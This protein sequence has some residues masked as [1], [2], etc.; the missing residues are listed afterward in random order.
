MHSHGK[1]GPHPMHQYTPVPHL[2]PRQQYSSKIT[3]LY[4]N[5]S[6]TNAVNSN[7]SANEMYTPLPRA[8]IKPYHES[9]FSDIKPP[10]PIENE[11]RNN[12]IAEGLA[13]SL[14]ARV[15]AP[16]IKEEVEVFERRQTYLPNVLPQPEQTNIIKAE[17]TE[18]TYKRESPIIHGPVRSIKRNSEGPR[19]NFSNEISPEPHSNTSTPLVDEVQEQPRLR[20]EEGKFI[21]NYLACQRCV[22]VQL[23]INRISNRQLVGLSSV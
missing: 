23:T 15:L 2:S 13:A 7:Y 22:S 19:T 6:R 16:P 12:F 5:Q 18:I 1:M 17:N 4:P 3:V 10:A 8:D 21:S 11:S 20:T 9:Y 14:Q